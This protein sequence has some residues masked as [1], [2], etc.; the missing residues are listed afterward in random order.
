MRRRGAA[1]SSIRHRRATAW[2]DSTIRFSVTARDAT[3]AAHVERRV[4]A[5][6][7]EQLVEDLDQGSAQ[8]RPQ[9]R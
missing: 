4:R 2:V 8:P 6:I 7:L 3:Q 9:R 1:V 5:G